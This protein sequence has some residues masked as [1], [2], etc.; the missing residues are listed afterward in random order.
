MV[1]KRWP[2]LETRN[3]KSVVSFSSGSLD[4]SASSVS[5]EFLFPGKL[6]AKTLGVP[7]GQY[8]TPVARK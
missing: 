2:F 4:D 7:S 6:A 5:V 3:P 1:A 8:I